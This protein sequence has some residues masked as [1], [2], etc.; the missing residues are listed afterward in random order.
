[1]ML[2]RKLRRGHRPLVLATRLELEGVKNIIPKKHTFH[3]ILELK[4]HS[5]GPDLSCL[6]LLNYG[7]DP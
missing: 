1:M 6:R 4:D 5:S 2:P 3:E 7:V